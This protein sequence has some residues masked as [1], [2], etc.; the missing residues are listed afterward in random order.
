MRG[1]LERLPA[2][3]DC[4]GITKCPSEDQ[5]RAEGMKGK[6]HGKEKFLALVV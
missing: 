1:E 5:E 6:G 3:Q 2:A 4:L